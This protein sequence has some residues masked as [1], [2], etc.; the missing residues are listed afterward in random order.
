VAAGNTDLVFRLFG[1]DVNASS[2]L[3]KVSRSA[4]D[5]SNKLAKLKLTGAQLKG[6]AI[7]AGII[8]LPGALNVVGSAAAGAAG[9]MA[10]LP[11]VAAAGGVAFGSLALATAGYAD[12]LK[13][14]RDPQKFAEALKYLA[15]AARESAREVKGLLPQLDNL[16]LNV[17]QNF[18]EQF[19]GDLTKLAGTYLPMFR[20]GLSQ[21]AASAGSGASGLAGF[22]GKPAQ[23]RQV[24]Q[25]LT[26]TAIAAQTLTKA[27]QPAADALL[28]LT[29]T[30]SQ[31]LP[32]MASEL[33][34]AASALDSFV[35]RAQASGALDRFLQNGITFAEQLATGLLQVGRIVSGIFG[36]GIGTGF[37]GF[38][39]LL[40]RMADVINGPAFQQGLGTVFAGLSSAAQ[41][42]AGVM[43]QLGAALVSISPA[44]GD[45]AAGFG[46][47][48][49]SAISTA[50][51]SVQQFAPAINGIAGVLAAMAPVLGPVVV[52]WLAFS[53]VAGPLAAGLNAARVAMLGARI[54][55]TYLRVAMLGLA[56]NPV[57]AVIVAVVALVAALVIAWKRSETFRA[58]VISVFKAVG[59]AVLLAVSTILNAFQHLFS[60]ASHIPGIGSA[61]GKVAEGFGI[62]RAS[63]DQMRGSLAAMPTHVG[64]AVDIA[65]NVS[66]SGPAGI[67]GAGKYGGLGQGLGVVAPGGQQKV[68]IGKPTTSAPKVS[69]GGGM[70]VGK[71]F[72]QGVGDGI[73]KKKDYTNNHFVKLARGLEA[74]LKNAMDRLTNIVKARE[75]YIKQLRNS[76]LEATS[77]TGF[78]KDESRAGT[79][80]AGYFIKYLQGRLTA[81]RQYQANILKL[82][83]MGLNRSTLQQIL[84]AGVDGGS[85]DAAA[86]AAGGKRAIQQVNSLQK[87]L[88]T[89]ASK[90]AGGV[91][92]QFY[93]SGVAAARGLVQGLQSQRKH[94][95]AIAKGLAKG[96]R[97]AIRKELKIKSPSRALAEDGR[98]AGLGFLQGLTGTRKAIDAAMTGLSRPG[99]SG[100]T[101][102]TGAGRS[103]VTEVHHHYTVQAGLVDDSAGIIRRLDRMA[104]QARANSSYRPTTLAFQG[105]R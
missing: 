103:Q 8:A 46:A 99:R 102:A 11:A 21:V 36:A 34:R 105:R 89:S 91:G 90:L 17:S 81:L 15:P 76:L 59:G 16:R 70:A 100:F 58:I 64:V 42:L 104:G 28:R 67:L 23:S 3:K 68:T 48:L 97:D 33:V 92:N 61:M 20:K 86:L 26:Q 57:G 96:L 74:R 35:K 6:A 87:G 18:F 53:R 22:L 12:A 47:G 72:G 85:D 13:D 41:S 7:G 37:G 63:I 98:F 66:I 52:G 29:S 77:I 1:R 38:V 19:K 83:K 78:E 14:I 93:A 31:W 82:R 60:A 40:T 25:I 84:D 43:P 73:K 45:L 80:G 54:A 69:Y 27:L 75:Q 32:F 71:G 44:L 24:Q 51:A 101:A 4:D 39:D 9:A 50:A 56:I 62:A 5:A 95:L 88:N 49:A 79:P 94:L 65:Y 55:A 30:G 10:T 2:A